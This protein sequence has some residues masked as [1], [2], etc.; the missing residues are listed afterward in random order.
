MLDKNKAE[1][2]RIGMMQG[3]F[4]NEL[5]EIVGFTEEEKAKLRG[6]LKEVLSAKISA[7]FFQKLS[8]TY[9]C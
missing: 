3:D 4:L 6:D 7:A 8:L 9:I 5:F 2:E 1:R